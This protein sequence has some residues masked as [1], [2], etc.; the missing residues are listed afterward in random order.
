MKESSVA[1]LI[2]SASASGNIHVHLHFPILRICQKW[3]E[4]HH[5]L[6]N[7][8]EEGS[9]EGTVATVLCVMAVCSNLS[10]LK[11]PICP[12]NKSRQPQQAWARSNQINWPCQGQ[13]THTQ[14]ATSS[15]K[16]ALRRGHFVW[17]T[18]LSPWP[19]SKVRVGFCNC[20]QPQPNEWPSLP[21][22]PPGA[23]PSSTRLSG[24]TSTDT[25]P[26]W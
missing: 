21:M 19:F 4:R 18:W 1:P 17:A 15:Y 22:C 2:L 16:L 5:W 13:H 20:R 14:A 9:C 3:L 11:S 6:E 12:L 7:T 24:P 23:D 26:Q 8:G 25:Q 10:L